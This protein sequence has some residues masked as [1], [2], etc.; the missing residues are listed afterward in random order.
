VTDEPLQQA[1]WRALLA[2]AAVA[3]AATLAP[4]TDGSLGFERAAVR[5]GAG[6]V[7]LPPGRP[8]AHAWLASG[9]AG[10]SV[11]AAAP[12][13]ARTLLDLYAPVCAPAAERPLTIAHLGQSL[14]GCIATASGD[15]YYVTGPDNVVHLHR[16]RALCDAVVVGAGTIERDDPLLTVRHVE[17]DNPLRVIVDPRRRLGTQAR[18]FADDAQTLL[19]YGDDAPS[20]ASHGAADV[21]TLPVRGGRLDLDALLAALR[22]RGCR[23]VFVEGGGATVSSFLEAGVLD[24]L[25]I[26]IAPL[27]TG[28]GRP[29]LSL[30]AR[31][32]IAECL[33]PAHRVFTMGG[34]VLF[35]CDLRAAGSV[36]ASASGELNRVV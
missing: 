34:D 31:D 7:R 8:D 1:A 2:A 33:R 3:R 26:A 12:P 23:A 16:L 28:S 29:G 35:D 19:I 27:V 15:S 13:A 5:I 18:V 17:G 4:E 11:A 20:G 25:Q 10:W 6:G 22:A 24:R 9:P 21:V 32:R 14:D 36:R 30:P